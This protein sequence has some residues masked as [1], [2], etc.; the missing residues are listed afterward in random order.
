M[1]FDVSSSEVVYQGWLTKSP[2]L[3]TKKQ[4]FK[5]VTPKWR[6]RWFVLQQGAMPGQFLLHYYTDNSTKK[7]KGTI[8][9]DQCEQVDT[10]LTFES[11]KTRYQFMFDIK[12]PKRVFYLAADTEQEMTRW[13]NFVCQVCGLRTYQQE[14]EEENRG[15][16]HPH[17]SSTAT[18]QSI[19][20]N[21]TATLTST[22]TNSATL[23]S[24]KEPNSAT[25]KS[26]KTPSSM[27]LK[28]IKS[29]P[30]TAPVSS[31]FPPAPT[32]LSGPY[33]HLTEC[34]TGGLHPMAGPLATPPAPYP[35]LSLVAPP[36]TSPQYINTP[37]P[38]DKYINT[39]GPDD[40]VTGDDSVFFPNSP[41]G[42]NSVGGVAVGAS[43]FPRSSVGSESGAGGVA[44]ALAQLRISEKKTGVAQSAQDGVFLPP[45]RPPKPHNLRN[46]PVN[47]PT[48]PAGDNYANHDDMAFTL[49]M[50]AAAES[51]D[52]FFKYDQ[53]HLITDQQATQDPLTPAST[54]SVD[55]LGG[56]TTTTTSTGS[57]QPPPLVD[58][59]L[60]PDRKP[61][62]G[63]ASVDTLYSPAAP[64]SG[65]VCPAGPPVERNLKPRRS[66]D[67]GPN[68]LM[69]NSSMVI[70][71]TNSSLVMPGYHSSNSSMVMPNNPNLK[72]GNVSMRRNSDSDNDGSHSDNG[73]RRNSSDEQ[74]FF[75]MPSLQQSTLGGKWDPFMIPAQEMIDQSVQYLDL[76]LPE[77]SNQESGVSGAPQKMKQTNTVYKTVDFMKT[78]AFNRTRQKVEE[79]RY[80][81]KPDQPL[82]N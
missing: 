13:V 24:T 70:P 33:M 37:G 23:R 55:S 9:L 41:R 21:N 34:Y 11:G 3:E 60:K 32:P 1:D 62:A 72:Y 43:S 81:I 65:P 14:E 36:R 54:T 78:E 31:N 58:R 45:G 38:D 2:P 40:S 26:L 53:D 19:K 74:I 28:S 47:Y 42:S 77:T 35:G 63:P 59:R 80:N 50:A 66:S 76:D 69:T 48:Q 22:N 57:S 68:S 49:Q 10:G 30:P 44:E 27:T 82:K 52:N 61:P 6:R 20:S 18:L 15:S 39:P 8:D 12:T 25:L 67:T 73:S 64:I 29:Q 16:P 71:G 56:T 51:T 7:L 5:A 17:P 46:V 4:I 79:Y 75:Y